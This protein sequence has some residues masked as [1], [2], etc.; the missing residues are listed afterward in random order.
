MKTLLKRW[1]LWVIISV[2]FC[3]IIG[4]L[5]IVPI[6]TNLYFITFWLSS[7]KFVQTFILY[8][9][10]IFSGMM[11]VYVFRE[12][13]ENG[14]E[15]IIFAKGISR[16]KI[17]FGKFISFLSFGLLF[18]LITS[19][20]A[21][22]CF[23]L[24]HVNKGAVSSLLIALLI[25]NIVSF[26]FFGSTGI[27]FSLF[28][29]KVIVVTLN[30]LLIIASVIFTSA[31]SASKTAPLDFI[32]QDS[33]FTVS[34]SSTANKDY[35]DVSQNSII[36]QPTEGKSFAE[37]LKSYEFQTQKE[38]W[39]QAEQKSSISF[40]NSLSLVE[41]LSNVFLTGGMNKVYLSSGSDR[42]IGNKKD[43]YYS[44]DKPFVEHNTKSIANA[45]D[46]NIEE[47]SLFNKKYNTFPYIMLDPGNFNRNET[48]KWAELNKNTQLD[49]VSIQKYLQDSRSIFSDTFVVYPSV[50]SRYQPIYNN[51]GDIYNY[52]SSDGSNHHGYIAGYTFYGREVS[53]NFI[54]VDSYL[55]NN[56]SSFEIDLFNW[57]LANIIF[58]NGI[59]NNALYFSKDNWVFELTKEWNLPDSWSKPTIVKTMIKQFQKYAKQLNLHTELEYVFEEMKFKQFIFNQLTG[60]NGIN[61]YTIQNDFYENE[62]S[63]NIKNVLWNDYFRFCF[64]PIYKLFT[65]KNYDTMSNLSHSLI[66][67]GNTLPFSV[68][69]NDPNNFL[70]KLLNGSLSP[71]VDLTK[72]VLPVYDGN[73]TP[74]DSLKNVLK[75]YSI[76]NSTT[77]D[78]VSQIDNTYGFFSP[79]G[80]RA[81]ALVSEF[82]HQLGYYF[83]SPE[84]ND[85]TKSFRNSLTTDWNNIIVTQRALFT[86][87]A[88][89]RITPVDSLIRIVFISL[90]LFSISYYKYLRYD[91]N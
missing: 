54:P 30:I 86:Y 56:L 12:H 83:Y 72:D 49:P 51:H 18:S 47:W 88:T 14:T 57:L 10:A 77:G 91:F 9:I 5:V 43:V 23:S 4:L 22:F 36:L 17:I 55:T 76:E 66:N 32:T 48:K 75:V 70:N 21:L 46:D 80:L 58:P 19:F 27:I 62:S 74:S 7:F 68:I 50:P 34:Y 45:T 53:K 78:H 33:K 39:N 73:L 15:L 85:W 60:K 61:N 89:N 63:T 6:F 41:Q 84:L 3:V 35:Q 87:S 1:S 69:S 24:P 29:N 37:I 52:Y 59:Y 13:Q 8:V 42:G 31:Y 16:N 71:Q 79:L 25:G 38:I 90:I 81:S 26:L 40:F 28:F 67:Y 44:I 82:C 2:Y 65:I 11:A 20:S 64:L